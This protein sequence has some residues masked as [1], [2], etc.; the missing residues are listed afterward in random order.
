MIIDTHS[1]L[2]FKDYDKDREEVISRS[3]KDGVFMINASID[4]ETSRKSVEISKEYERGVY[5]AIGLHPLNIKLEKFNKEKYKLLAKKG[6]VVAIGEIGLDYLGLKDGQKQALVEQIKFAEELN[7]PIIFHCRKAHDD[8][9][10]ILRNFNIKGVIHSFTGKWRQAEQYLDMGFYLGFNGIIFK[11][12]LDKIIKRVPL[13]RLLVETDC[14][15]LPPPSVSGRNEPI[16][17]KE[18][19][20]RI[21]EVR[22]E[23][24]NQIADFSFGNAKRLFNI[25]Y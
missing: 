12:N 10:D 1:H 20:K 3:L 7:L 8:L 13:D 22:K 18:V 17:V 24:F 23:N 5:S 21:A 6:K 11:L 4:Y 25:E 14:P 2:N 16:F 9:I 15:F 19:I